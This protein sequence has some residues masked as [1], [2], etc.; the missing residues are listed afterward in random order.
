[1]MVP[2]IF[3][4]VLSLSVNIHA[5]ECDGS[6]G[7]GEGDCDWDSDCLPGLVCNWDWWWGTDHCEAGPYTQ[8]YE[9]GP[10]GDWGN[11]TGNCGTTGERMRHRICFPPENGGYECPADIDTEVE[12]CEM[13]P[14]PVHC[15]WG[16]PVIGECSVTCGEGMR[17]DTRVKLIEADFGGD[18]CNG[19][20]F[21]QEYCHAG[22]CP[23]ANNPKC[24]PTT[25]EGYNKH[26]CTV[27]EPCGLG[28]GDCD[29]DDECA[30]GFVCGTNNCVG[31]PNPKAD[32]CQL[33][34]MEGYGNPNCF[35]GIADLIPWASDVKAQNSMFKECCSKDKPCGVGQGDC[36]HDDECVGD[37]KCGNNNC[38][39][40]PSPKADC[41]E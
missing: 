23:P 40:F 37:L 33:P 14:C 21:V 2:T 16:E 9:W 25:W 18:D 17:I 15:E 41:C 28:E 30:D 13:E 1:M 5:Y 29:T 4:L 26:C 34:V 12:Q 8:N 6:C 20:A 32:C 27:E 22:D 24:S 35:P 11:C 39:G 38:V 10:F 36:D 7:Q 3:F 19:E 31:F